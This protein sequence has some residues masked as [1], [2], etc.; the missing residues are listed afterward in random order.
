M[1][2][3]ARPGSPVRL[4]AVDFGGS[5]G[6]V[7]AGVVDADGIRIEGLE[8]FENVPMT[9]GGGLRWNADDLFDRAARAARLLQ[10]RGGAFDALAI[11]S[12][13]TDYAL[14]AHG[15][16][17]EQPFHQREPRT[18]GAMREVHA[19]VGTW[20]LYERT[21]QSSLPIMTRYQLVADR[22]RVAL[23]R[24]DGML[25]L[26][27]YFAHR[28]S[29]IAVTERTNATTTGLVSVQTG[30]WDDALIET[31]RLP[32]GLFADIVPAGTVLGSLR[33]E[34]STATGIDAST[35]VVAV[36]SH[37]TAS[38]I[39][40]LPSTHDD[41]A[42]ISLGTWSLVGVETPAP[43]ITR[44]AMQAGFTN[45]GG[46]DDRNRFLRIL[47]G[48]W[49]LNR[50]LAELGEPLPGSGT[51]SSEL[52][53]RAAD[54]PRPAALFDPTD[55]VFIA[56]G[57]MLERLR[58]HADLPADPEPAHLVRLVVESL[59]ACFAR[60][61]HEASEL[62]GRPVREVHI[63]GGGSQNT[64]LCRLVADYAG[65]PVLAGPAEATALGNLLVQARA[66][67]AIGSDVGEL[68]SLVRRGFAPL[69]FEPSAVPTP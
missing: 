4:A 61:A 53:R 13:S 21:G 39:A 14:M 11:D 10:H 69:R 30:D 46:L 24:A 26:P 64:L 54:L 50:C 56:P 58:Q 67:G 62:S 12:W 9:L 17:L 63:V 6:R 44:A 3:F 23:E 1:A 45:E 65:L 52:L 18:L 36:A 34:V 28:L 33:R 37:D 66:L 41:V 2:S 29:G 32:R 5:S 7:V 49:I 15:Q 40:A 60:T 51:R 48:M 35:R 43:V 42:Y 59:A 57:S 47:P 38:A 55:P 8:R 31:L 20:P 22:D 27:D 68:R 25:M 19:T 16:L